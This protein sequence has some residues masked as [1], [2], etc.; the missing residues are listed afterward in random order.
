MQ[1]DLF[2]AYREYCHKNGLKAMSQANF[3]WDVENYYDKVER[4]LE[5]VSRRKRGRASGS[6]RDLAARRVVPQMRTEP[7]GERTTLS[8]KTRLL[9]GVE[10]V[11]P[12][13][14]FLT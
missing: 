3:S 9:C 11:E 13:F 1:E 4:G 6:M 10:Q 2:Q 14:L 5:R 7:N 12:L 8:S